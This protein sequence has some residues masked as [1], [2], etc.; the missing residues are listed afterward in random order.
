MPNALLELERAI[1]AS[2]S[3]HSCDPVD[4]PDWSAHNP[5]RGQCASTALVIQDH[6]GGELLLAEVL[7]ADGTRQGVHFWNQLPTGQEVD[8]TREQFVYGE[9]IQT[10]HVVER[11]PDTSVGRLAT[12][13][14][15]LSDRVRA[16]LAPQENA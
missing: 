11:P 6:L 15:T 1:R 4:L 3:P 13:Y 16:T 2:W 12:Q 5:A 14:R 8:L 7:H 9:T 10:P